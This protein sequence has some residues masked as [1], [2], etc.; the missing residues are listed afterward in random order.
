V[1]DI[2]F[3]TKSLHPCDRFSNGNDDAYKAFVEHDCQLEDWHEIEAEARSTSLGSVELSVFRNRSTTLRR[4]VRQ[5]TRAPGDA[6]FAYVQVSGTSTISQD[7]RD[8][9]LESGGLILVDTQRPHTITYSGASEQLAAQ[10][11]RSEIE[12]RIGDISRA[13]ALGVDEGSQVVDLLCLA[14]SSGSAGK[15]QLS[16]VRS[17]SLLRLKGVI[18][19]RLS[20]C[21]TTCAEVARAAG[22]SV[23]YA[24]QLLATEARSLDRYIWERR[25][26]RCRQAFDDPC[27]DAKTI[28]EIAYAWGFNDVSHFGRLFKARYRVTPRDYRAHSRVVRRMDVNGAH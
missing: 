15:R 25:L 5:I 10:I 13:T 9:T 18:E 21:E 24:N 27:Q 2:I 19:G 11:S 3:S 23:R 28:T 17:T 7:A 20:A 16:S 12:A 1:S 26:E 6:I 4:S 14:L 22:M 8:I